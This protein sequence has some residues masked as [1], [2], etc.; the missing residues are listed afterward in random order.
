MAVETANDYDPNA[1]A[2]DELVVV[3]VVNVKWLAGQTKGTADIAIDFRGMA[4]TD[5]PIEVGF[6][7]HEVSV[8]RAAAEVLIHLFLSLARAA[9]RKPESCVDRV[10][11]GDSGNSVVFTI[12]SKQRGIPDFLLPVDPGPGSD[13]RAEAAQAAADRLRK[14][15]ESAIDKR[16][17]LI[18]DAVKTLDPVKDYYPEVLVMAISTAQRSST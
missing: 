9:I 13:T 17:K 15:I 12:D 18:A 8:A 11:L 1:A 14:D 5:V 7:C 10:D 3:S 2:G 4:Q 16:R 6:A